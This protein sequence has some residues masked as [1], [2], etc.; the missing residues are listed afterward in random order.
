MVQR[1][2]R[3]ASRPYFEM[4]EYWLCQG[5]LND[6]YAEFMVEEDK[7]TFSTSLHSQFCCQCKMPS[8]RRPVLRSDQAMQLQSFYLNESEM[9]AC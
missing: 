2:L 9:L 3:A 1:L 5:L 8:H 4:L 7:V 6:P